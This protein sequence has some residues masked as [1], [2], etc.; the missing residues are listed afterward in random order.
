MRLATLF[1]TA[2]F[3]S[4]CSLDGFS[5]LDDDHQITLKEPV[6]KKGTVSFYLHTDTTYSNGPGQEPLKQVLFE[7]EGLAKFYV[8]RSNSNVRI[9]FVWNEYDQNERGFII[10]RIT[11]PGPEKYFFQFSWDSTEGFSDGYMNGVS[12]RNRKVVYAPWEM[13]NV[14]T[15]VVLSGG[16]MKVTDIE[17]VSSYTPES[18]LMKSVLQGFQD[19]PEDLHYTIKETRSIDL[20]KRRGDLIFQTEMSEAE[21]MEGW[22]LEGP[23]I[24]EYKEGKMI[25]YSEFP[26]I[27]GSGKGHFNFWC[28]Q[29]FPDNFVIEWDFELLDPHGCAVLQFSAKGVN[30][31]DLLDPSLAPRDG[32][33]GQY[34]SGDI[35]S[36]LLTYFFNRQVIQTAR[37]YLNL[38]KNIGNYEIAH[39]PATID[40][41]SKEFHHLQLIKNGDHIQFLVDGKLVINYHDNDLKRWGSPALKDGK[42]GFRQMAGTMV[43]YKNFKVWNLK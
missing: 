9:F 6:G 17:V 39:G 1:I 26:D 36:Y 4:L 14:A 28:P 27:P 24:I 35:N 20:K 23:G 11:L 42:I 43:G 29:D 12:L 41:D 37:P 3:L 10:Q 16:P 32:K 19:N 8:Q 30:G 21:S 5:F 38:F 13:N 7:L 15:R 40:P 18:E 33:F 22:V 31:E 25:M 2:V 34:T